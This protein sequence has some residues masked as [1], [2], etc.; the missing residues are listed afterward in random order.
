MHYNHHK[1]VLA[2]LIS[3]SYFTYKTY[4]IVNKMQNDIFLT[5]S[6]I[7]V[8]AMHIPVLLASVD[9]SL[10]LRVVRAAKNKHLVFIFSTKNV[11]YHMITLLAL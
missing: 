6:S 11:I 4:N 8:P 1:I 10:F 9:P 5:Y 2:L 3:S 7:T